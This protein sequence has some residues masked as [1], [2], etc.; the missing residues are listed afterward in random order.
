MGCLC[1]HIKK[2][3]ESLLHVERPFYFCQILNSSAPDIKGGCRLN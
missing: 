2:G 1:L 3:G